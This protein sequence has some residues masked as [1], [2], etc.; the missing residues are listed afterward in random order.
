MATPPSTGND[1]LPPPRLTGD[2]KADAA[3]VQ[4]W[5][6]DVYERLALTLNVSGQLADHE[7]RITALENP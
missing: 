6:T 5:M 2:P 3:V 1:L 4:R 7:A